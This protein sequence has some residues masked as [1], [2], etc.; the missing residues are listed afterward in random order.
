MNGMRKWCIL[1]ERVMPT[2]K[3]NL[4]ALTVKLTRCFHRDKV[5]CIRKD[6]LRQEISER[7]VI[8]VEGSGVGGC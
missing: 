1:P 2:V 6:G 7:R 8:F 4:V 5:R 3:W